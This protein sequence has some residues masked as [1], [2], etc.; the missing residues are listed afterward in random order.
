MKQLIHAIAIATALLCLCSNVQAQGFT[1]NP[2][3]DNKVIIKVNGSNYY[4]NALALKEGKTRQRLNG[5]HIEF[6]K[7]N[8]RIVSV[9]TQEKN[10]TWT[11][12]IISNRGK[13]GFIC[14]GNACL[15]IGDNDCNDMILSNVCKTNGP[16][17]D[18][19]CGGDLPVCTC[20]R[21]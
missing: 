17:V 9:K 5:L 15:C 12:N 19:S 20:N 10:G 21:N 18:G 16:I 6:V 13:Q 8:K 14:N 4:F 7:R 1:S 2:K 3:Q 11:P